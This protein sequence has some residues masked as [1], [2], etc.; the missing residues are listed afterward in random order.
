MEVH[1]EDNEEAV[2]DESPEMPIESPEMAPI[3]VAATPDPV[4]NNSVIVEPV[5]VSGPATK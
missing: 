2:A 5:S 4:E 1:S 3:I